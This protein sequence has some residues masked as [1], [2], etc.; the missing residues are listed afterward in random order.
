LSTAVVIGTPDSPTPEGQFSVDD[1]IHYDPPDPSYGVGAL[2]LT[3]P[4]A[5]RDW[6]DW[7]VAIHGLNDVGRLGGTG[8]LGCVH[9]P[10]AL[11]QRLLELP[12]GTP[13][14][15]TD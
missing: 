12:V 10:T 8:S 1:V 14:D 9:V 15:I 2:E 7:R 6:V 5:N 13:V 11:L 4:P 3:V